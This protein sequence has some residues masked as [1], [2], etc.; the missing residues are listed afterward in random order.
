MLR[1][2]SSYQALLDGF[3]WEI[4]RRYNIGVDAVTRHADGSGRPA[5]LQL[6]AGGRLVRTFSFDEIEALT[7][8]FANVLRGHGI[9]RGERVAVLLGQ[10]PE[11]AIA[12]IAAFKAAC[13]SVPL[14]AL[15][16]ADALRYRLAD[17]G[18]AALVTDA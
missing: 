17:S 6:D 4:P 3:A 18:A 10:V 11:T 8:R 13:I 16:G 5:L 1:R 2:A 14:F 7:N 12:H 9:G 15:F